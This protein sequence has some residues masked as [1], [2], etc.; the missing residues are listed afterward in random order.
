MSNRLMKKSDVEWIGE[1]PDEWV[2]LRV[3]DG[4]TQ[5]KSKAHQES[6]VVLSL[7]R[8]G[9]KVRDMSSA[10]G[11]FA[12]SY[13]DYNP[14]DVDDMLINPMDLISGDNCSL[15]KVVGVISPAYV[16]LRHKEGFCP[17]YYQYYFKYQYW[18]MAFFAHGKGV[19]IDNRWTLNNE[20][21]MKFPL[22]APPLEVQ[23]KIADFLDGKCAEIDGLVDDIQ[24]QIAVLEQ[25][26][27]SV[28]TEAV[29][30]GLNPDVPMK[31][32]GIEWVGM[33]PEHWGANRLK[34]LFV[35]KKGLS[36]TKENL[37]ETGLPVVS[38]GQI[39]SKVNT[40]V[41][42]NSELLR[43][44]DYSYQKQYP[45]CEVFKHDFIFAD[46]SEDY[47]GCGNCVY[48]RD[49]ETI[50][51]GY[52]SIILHSKHNQDNRYF[53][54]LFKTDC[55]RN[56]IREA[57]SG[58]KLFSISQKTLLNTSV[59]IPG[60]VEQQEIAN[61]L[62]NKC[63]EIDAVIAKKKEQLEELA[64]YKKSLIYEYVTGKKEVPCE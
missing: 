7:A 27:K 33:I 3:K 53:A 49:D 64:E 57:A 23:Q 31:D 13:F 50:F 9:V 35:H 34:Y 24:E 59:L 51:A 56:Q 30:K 26:K 62:D 1:I 48:K 47:D 6:P 63:S 14:V 55:W 10:E 11:Q 5:K 44:V 15:S 38:Y 19:S 39:H 12:E 8:S 16:N 45:Q 37:V 43:Y 61:Y 20:T 58:V 60:F 36:I 52:H 25:Y 4:F 42:I 29:T 32:S 17:D 54:Y 28:I 18:C 21:L 40:G 46:T 22:L 41:D 2:V